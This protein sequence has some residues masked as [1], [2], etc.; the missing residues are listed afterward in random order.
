MN[1]YSSL[2]L[3]DTCT[4]SDYLRRDRSVVKAIHNQRSTSLAVS[5]I[6]QYEIQVGLLNKPS[7]QPEYLPQLNEFYNKVNIIG[8]NDQIAYCAA[9]IKTDLKKA[10]TPIGEP[11]IFIAATAIAWDLTII[12]SNTKDFEKIEGLRIEEWKK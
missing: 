10:G 1:T 12:T 8:I 11:D 4:L 2:Y 7:L 9:G 5:V 3:L 6:T